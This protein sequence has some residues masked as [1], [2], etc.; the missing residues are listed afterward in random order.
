MMQKTNDKLALILL[1]RCVLTVL[2]NDDNV[3]RAKYFLENNVLIDTH[4]DLSY[5]LRN[6]FKNQLNYF[7]LDDV[8]IYQANS[9][10]AGT[11]NVTHTD[12]KRIEQGKL[13]AQFWAVYGGC[14]ALG[15][16]ALSNQ[17]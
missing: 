13:G 17:L 4:N 14:D 12:L 5:F 7:D 3:R 6:N 1:F 15:K 2:S 9:S 11:N 16:D 10:L 8:K